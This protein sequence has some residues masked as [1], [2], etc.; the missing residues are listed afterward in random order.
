ASGPWNTAGVG[1]LDN[2]TVAI[3]ATLFAANPGTGLE[4]LNRTDAQ[5]LQATGRLQNGADFNVATHDV[6]SGTLNVAANNVGLDPS[7]AVG[8][9]DDNNGNAANGGTA[10]VRI[11]PDI[12]FSNKTSGGSQLRPTVQNSRMSIGHLSMSDAIGSTKN[13][14]SRP[15]RAL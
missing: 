14:A 12:R 4:R 9:N 13:S 7:F 15:L 1:N 11:G 10:R 6:N 5:W 2:R 3:T 8:E